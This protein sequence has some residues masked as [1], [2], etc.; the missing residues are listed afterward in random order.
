[1]E[2]IYYYNHDLWWEVE[3][4]SLLSLPL[5]FLGE[6]LV[7]EKIRVLFFLHFRSN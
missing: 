1:M 2:E 4:G 6:C 3:S 5:L 7:A